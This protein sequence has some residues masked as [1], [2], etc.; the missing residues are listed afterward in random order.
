MIVVDLWPLPTAKRV[1]L[2][3]EGPFDLGGLRVRPAELAVTHDGER[4]ELQPRAMQVLVALAKARPEVVSR[5]RL[6]EQCWEGR[7]VGDDAVNRIILS[8]RHLAQE[9]T[10][11]PFSIETVPR[12][13]HRLIVDEKP[14]SKGTRR[15][16]R[17]WLWAGAAALLLLLVAGGF[18]AWQQRQ[19]VAEP[20]SIAVL[21]FRNL[22]SGDPYFAEGIGE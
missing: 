2:G 11:A 18:F 5:D 22:S 3:E 15:I 12:V 17:R 6:I 21:P 8:L 13:G 1:D 16:P 9:F 10:P 20:A 7:V 19:A 4:R 14:A